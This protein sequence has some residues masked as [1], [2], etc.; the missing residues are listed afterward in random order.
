MGVGFLRARNWAY[1]IETWVEKFEGV[2]S[3]RRT[4]IFRPSDNKILATSI[5]NW[6]LLNMQ[7]RKPMRVP[8]T[9]TAYYEEV[10][11]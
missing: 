8:E 11:Q 9:F 10:N 3:I 5:T 7:T 6:C 1:E 4:K 2:R